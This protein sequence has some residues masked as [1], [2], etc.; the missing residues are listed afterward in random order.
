[1]NRGPEIGKVTFSY[2]PQG[3][4]ELALTVGE[5]V[6]ITEK[7]DNGWCKGEKNGK[8][9]MFPYNYVEPASPSEISAYNSASTTSSNEI[10]I[11]IQD[12]QGSSSQLSFKKDD[13]I[14]VLEK[15]PTG[16]WK[17]EL[18]GRTGVFPRS[19]VRLESEAPPDDRKSRRNTV[20]LSNGSYSTGTPPPVPDRKRASTMLSNGN[21]NA[22]GVGKALYSYK[23][24]GPGNDYY[25]HLYYLYS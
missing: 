21:V 3:P 4:E 23:G 22:I 13:V 24:T 5:L 15:F 25:D 1:M 2:E 10:V 9:G 7:Y 19:A 17:G 14:N 12:F 20:N 6:T 8:I 16:W 18:N 11:A